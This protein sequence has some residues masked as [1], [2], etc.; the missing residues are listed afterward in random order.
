MSRDEPRISEEEARALWHRAAEWRA[1]GRSSPRRSSST[2]V[3]PRGE[4][5]REP[6]RIDS[7]RHRDRWR[8]LARGPISYPRAALRNLTK[9]RSRRTA[10]ERPVHTIRAAANEKI[11]AN[12]WPPSPQ[13]SPVCAYRRN[14]CARCAGAWSAKD[15]HARAAP[16]AASRVR[17][18]VLWGWPARPSRSS[19]RTSLSSGRGTFRIKVRHPGA[20]ASAVA[21]TALRS[22]SGPRAESSEINAPQV[23]P[24]RTSIQPP[25]SL[26]TL[27]SPPSDKRDR[28]RP[29]TTWRPPLPRSRPVAGPTRS[30]P[31]GAN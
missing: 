24:L 12:S 3:A 9:R 27:R 18:P 25:M 1:E 7:R 30:P 13:Y 19:T 2:R 28:P 11:P 16:E 10:R 14:C 20:H 6:D 22:A 17:K 5:D 23:P 8:F 15:S 26:W 4:G 29:D 31:P 21:S